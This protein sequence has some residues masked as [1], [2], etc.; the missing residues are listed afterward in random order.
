MGADDA[1]EL[2]SRILASFQ[3]AFD[4]PPCEEFEMI[5]QRNFSEDE[6]RVCMFAPTEDQIK[7]YP[8]L[9]TAANAPEVDKLD[10]D[11]ALKKLKPLMLSLVFLLHRHAWKSFMEEFIVRGGLD[12]LAAMLAEPNLYYRGQVVEIMVTATDCDVYD[13]FVPR[14]D[15]MGRT[16]HIRLLELSDHPTFLPNLLANRTGSYPGGSMR[17]LTLMAFWLSWVRAMYTKDQVLQLSPGMVAALKKWGREPGRDEDGNIDLSDIGEAEEDQIIEVGKGNGGDDK[18]EEGEDIKDERSLVKT[19]LQDFTEQQ[20]RGKEG[21]SQLQQESSSSSSSLSGAVNA[22]VSGITAPEADAEVKE[23]VQEVFGRISDSQILAFQQGK[24][25]KAQVHDSSGGSS[26][27]LLPV[28]PSSAS[29]TSKTAAAAVT[30]SAGDLKAEGNRLF[31]YGDYLGAL[32]SYDQAVAAATAAGAGAGAGDTAEAEADFLSSV[33]FNR[34]ACYWKVATKL[35][36]ALL[37]NSSSKDKEAEGRKDKEAEEDDEYMNMALK[38]AGLGGGDG[39]SEL[40]RCEEECRACL[41]LSP[42][43]YKASYRLAA[44]LLALKKPSAALET[45]EAAI[46][47]MGEIDIS[48]SS[49][50]G[51]NATLQATFASLKELRSRCLAACMVQ[52]RKTNSNSGSKSDKEGTPQGQGVLSGPAAKILQ[53]LQ[54]RKDRER[55]KEIHAEGSEEWSAPAEDQPSARDDS[56]SSSNN[57]VGVGSSSKK[58]DGDRDVDV[59]EYFGQ[60]N[61]YTGS[62][63]SSSKAKK[64]VAGASSSAVDAEE[65]KRK[66]EKAAAKQEAKKASRSRLLQALEAIRGAVRTMETAGYSAE[67]VQSTGPA[68]IAALQSAQAAGSS[69]SS[70]SKKKSNSNT[71]SQAFKDASFML[72][73]ARIVA[74]L[75]SLD[76]TGNPS[77]HLPL[78]KQLTACERFSSVLG[79]ALFGNDALKAAI[80]S[81][82]G[83][84][85]EQGMDDLATVLTT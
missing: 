62:S 85:R 30:R 69:G 26:S 81:L 18:G 11:H 83:K 39:S 28:P 65:E 76:Y 6:V 77:E 41:S 48:S 46:R 49:S 17:C 5:L 12:I 79:M 32:T 22:D 78:L 44:V 45:T 2:A 56:S 8:A 61:V 60:S 64:A 70:S 42:D 51:S 4:R 20:F 24:T 59:G 13:W 50:S 58:Q 29:T 71:L 68:L 57:S 21:Y 43:H 19:L 63:S 66:K 14:T 35:A 73:E 27:S 38:Q 15:I 31:G 23:K 40:A 36:P 37:G 53:A 34:A 84:C 74:C 75:L 3:S 52:N 47:Q 72:D 7:F 54:R 80:S 33:Y 25:T 55:K 10:Q 16:L 1:S 82:V 67:A 9:M